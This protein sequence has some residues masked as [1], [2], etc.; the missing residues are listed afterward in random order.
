MSKIGFTTHNMFRIR[1]AQK[2]KRNDIKVEE[3]YEYYNRTWN[4]FRTFTQ[5]L[6]K[7]SIKDTERLSKKP[8][9]VE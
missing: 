5:G 8:D 7:K 3:M 6:K 4:Y 2:V 1:A 9:N